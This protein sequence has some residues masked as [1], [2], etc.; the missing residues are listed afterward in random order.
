MKNLF[1]HFGKALNLF[2]CRF[3]LSFAHTLG[4]LLRAIFE[5]A[6]PLS[7]F[8]L[9]QFLLTFFPMSLLLYSFLHAMQLL[10][11][12]FPLC[13]AAYLFPLRSGCNLQMDPNI[14][15]VILRTNLKR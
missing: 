1:A 14:I 6:R 2:A 4:C 7:G 15:M 11:Y 9:R 13:F 5:S 10:G 3:A 8:L 12:R